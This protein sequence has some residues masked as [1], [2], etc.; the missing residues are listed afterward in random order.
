MENVELLPLCYLLAN[1]VSILAYTVKDKIMS[2]E[3]T[4]DVNST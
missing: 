4:T 1:N 2:I 3:W